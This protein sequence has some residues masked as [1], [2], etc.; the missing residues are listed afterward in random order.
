[1]EYLDPVEDIATSPHQRSVNIPESR[2]LVETPPSSGTLGVS[3]FMGWRE[4]RKE[5]MRAQFNKRCKETIRAGLK[6][7]TF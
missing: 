5:S 7:I 4:K 1:M 6:S 3:S 2:P